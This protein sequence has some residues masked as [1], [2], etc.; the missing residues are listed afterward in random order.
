MESGSQP[1][2]S[3]PIISQTRPTSQDLR[4]QRLAVIGIVAAL[5]ILIA[6]MIGGVIFLLQPATPTDRIR[7]IFIIFMALESLL[8]GLVL[9]I[10][11]FQLARLINLLQ[12]EIKP[13]L[14]STNETVSTLRG[15]TNFLSDNL[16]E[17]VIKM[18]E[19]FAGLQQ[20]LRVFG[21]A[22]GKRKNSKS[23]GE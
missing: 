10:L 13:I 17:P 15:T 23:Q 1:A 19:Y 12:N 11:I 7:D 20:A 6:L 9:V 5:V 3:P 21:L 18:N 22:R 14:D 16:V 8:L 4:R 2:G